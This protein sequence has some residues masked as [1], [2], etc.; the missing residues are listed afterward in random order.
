[1][2]AI[3]N[4]LTNRPGTAPVKNNT[5]GE[6]KQPIKL[7]KKVVR[8]ATDMNK[9][10]HQD[11]LSEIIPVNQQGSA[12]HQNDLNVIARFVKHLDEPVSPEDKATFVKALWTKVLD[13]RLT[14]NPS[15]AEQAP[16][17]TLFQEVEKAYKDLDAQAVNAAA[18]SLSNFLSIPDVDKTQFEADIKK[19]LTAFLT[20]PTASSANQL[21][22]H[23]K[24][25]IELAGHLDNTKRLTDQP[26]AVGESAERN[27]WLQK[28]SS[29]VSMVVGIGQD[30]QSKDSERDTMIC[31][32]IF[33]MIP[34]L[35]WFAAAYYLHKYGIYNNSLSLIDNIIINSH[36]L[37][38]LSLLTAY[39]GDMM[40]HHSQLMAIKTRLG[41]TLES[42]YSALNESA[43]KDLKAL[44][45][46]EASKTE[47]NNKQIE[48]NSEQFYNLLQDR[49]ATIKSVL[50]SDNIRSTLTQHASE[51]FTVALFPNV[52]K[53]VPNVDKPDTDKPLKLT[54]FGIE[55]IINTL[56]PVILATK[57]CFHY[58]EVT[59]SNANQANTPSN[60]PTNA[61]REHNNKIKNAEINVHDLIHNVAFRDYGKGYKDLVNFS[62]K[63]PTLMEVLNEIEKD[64]D[65]AILGGVN[66]KSDVFK[67]TITHD[68][69][70]YDMKA[71][72]Q[73]QQVLKEILNP[74]MKRFKNPLGINSALVVQNPATANQGAET[75][76]HILVEI[77]NAPSSAPA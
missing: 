16:A 31:L 67:F 58:P 18:S 50:T 65:N 74:F 38:K 22:L 4:N 24:G 13:N 57:E 35:D 40:S 63:G 32:A 28:F 45:C 46:P 30:E 64:P 61:F 76:D 53:P 55:K 15:P 34:I 70:P 49:L 77:A 71:L 44:L 69:T 17:L 33:Q 43:A 11:K 52:D 75:V 72:K 60:M 26:L 36:Q 5:P 56:T 23:N 68:G 25:R 48:K 66:A 12:I 8:Y 29:S 51:L 20:P 9:P 2:P 3:F 62:G 6:N 7:N 27:E 59:K 37:P 54:A 47:Q 21:G 42:K 1:M 73:N 19:E 41:E 10:S 39:T 14:K